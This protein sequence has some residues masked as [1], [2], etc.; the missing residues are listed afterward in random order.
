MGTPAFGVP[1]LDELARSGQEVV[2][3]VTQEDRPRG[4]K[5]LSSPVPV[6]QRAVELG[7]R[8]LQPA[9]LTDPVFMDQMKGCAPDLIVVVAYGGFL[10]RALW[11]LP[12]RGAINLHP[13]LLPRYRGAAPIQHAL[14]NGDTETGVT[15][16]YLGEGMDAGDIILQEKLPIAPAD[17][18]ESLSVTLAA[19]GA[20]ALL[21]AVR[22]IEQGGAERMPQDESRVTFAPK[23][24]K[25]AGAVD[26]S[27]PA[28]ALERR[29]RAFHPWPGACT[30]YAFHGKKLRL[31]ILEA[32]VVGGEGDPGLVS[33]CDSDG[34]H[35]GTG[36]G[37]LV[38]TR[39]QPEGK[40][41]MT[42]AQFSAGHRDLAGTRLG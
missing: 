16:L 34:I 14:L 26:W 18:A 11:G 19:Q 3:V 5:L 4:R 21:R 7:M 1:S 28:I 42:A 15:I 35:V 29:V 38:L 23:L 31:K 41:I 8:V 12:P 40:R 10:P 9:K 36:S 13:S 6:K 33:R 17:T 2:A 37:M 22:A 30:L 39:V 32:M 27:L 20:R 25:E 24:T